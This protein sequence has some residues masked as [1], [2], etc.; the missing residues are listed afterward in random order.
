MVET[1]LGIQIITTLFAIFM[2]YI[3]F[4]HYKRG[5]L[6]LVEFIFWLITWLLLIFLA[7]F[8][9]SLDPLISKLFVARAMD[10]ITIGALIVLTYLGFANHI[11]V[12]SIQRQTETLVRQFA[13]K[14][15]TK[16]TVK[17]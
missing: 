3:A 15:E 2:V 12:K 6:G 5:N 10:L 17:R 8:P 14:N 9:K 13:L 7:L 1:F 4:L 16:K 11:G